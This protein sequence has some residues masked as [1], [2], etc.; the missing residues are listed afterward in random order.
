MAVYTK[1]T[2][3]EMQDLVDKYYV[4]AKLVEMKPI[5]DGITNTNYLI[6]I[7]LDRDGHSETQ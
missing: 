4:N 7:E 6:T 5:S 3:E 2:F 1:L